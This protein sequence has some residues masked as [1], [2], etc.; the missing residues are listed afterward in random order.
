MDSWRSQRSQRSHSRGR[1]QPS[2]RWANSRSPSES[3]S[4]FHPDS[5]RQNPEYVQVTPRDPSE[6]YRGMSPS[7]SRSRS[8]Q[9]SV[10]SHSIR[11]HSISRS[12]S[13]GPP[14]DRDP[15]VQDRPPSRSSKAWTDSRTWTDKA[16]KIH[17]ENGKLVKS[18]LAIMGALGAAAYVARRKLPDVLPGSLGGNSDDKRSGHHNRSSSHEQFERAE[19]R[20]ERRRHGEHV[21][22]HR[23]Y[24]SFYEE[25][26]RPRPGEN[27][28]VGRD[29]RRLPPPPPRS[30]RAEPAWSQYSASTTTTT[31]YTEPAAP[32]PW[33][34]LS[35]GLYTDDDDKVLY[36]DG[37]GK[38]YVEEFRSGDRFWPGA[39]LP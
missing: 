3:P 6:S 10:R 19:R 7:R 34:A 12:R 30:D 24:A 28:P 16:P 23:R 4:R 31:R 1:S 14:L 17:D 5:M 39:R 8:R 35:T 32:S 13:R 26:G 27:Y 37:E 15:Y 33:A 22:R 18:S 2:V 9:R 38:R 20:E 36:V 11:S 29:D 25:D 21:E